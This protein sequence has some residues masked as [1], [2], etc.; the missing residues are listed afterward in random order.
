MCLYNRHICIRPFLKL[1]IDKSYETHNKLFRKEIKVQ[2]SRH[3]D[4]KPFKAQAEELS[5]LSAASNTPIWGGG[6][7]SDSGPAEI[8]SFFSLESLSH[9]VLL[10][11]SFLCIF[12][13]NSIES[14]KSCYPET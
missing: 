12:E 5:S 1:G 10:R 13:S 6:V 11:K 2:D 7:Q 4:G 3:E 8:L 9:M 14:C